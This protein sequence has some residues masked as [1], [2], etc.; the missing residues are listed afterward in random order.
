MQSAP[1]PL[2]HGPALPGKLV[3]KLEADLPL[4]VGEFASRGDVVD[5]VMLVN[6]SLERTA[7]VQLADLRSLGTLEEYSPQDGHL[8]KCAVEMYLPGGQGVLMKLTR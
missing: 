4:M 1:A 8:A 7:K 3:T 2:D 5:H 6:L